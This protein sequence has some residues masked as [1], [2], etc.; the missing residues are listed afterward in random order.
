MGKASKVEE[1]VKGLD[2]L[3]TLP[4]VAMKILELVRNKES[5]LKQIADAISN[6]PSLSAEILKATNSPFYGLPKKV[7][8]IQHAVNLLGINTIKSLALGFSLVKNFRNKKPGE[9][10]YG[11]Y[12]KDSLIGAMSA[13]LLAEK[14]A[15]EAKE[16][17][18][19]LGL[20][21]NIGTLTLVNCM[22]RQYNLVMTKILKDGY[23]DHEAE[24]QII[25][26]DHMEVGEYL[27]KSW[28]LPDSFSAPIGW[29][30]Q[31][32]KLDTND[33][34]LKKYTRILHLSSLIIEM[35]N[36]S[37][38][39]LSLGFLKHWTQ[40]YDFFDKLDIDDLGSAINQNVQP[41]FALFDLEIKEKID[42]DELIKAANSEL[43]NLSQNLIKDLLQKRSEIELLRQQVD[44]D[45]MTQ[46]Y[47][48]QRFKDLLDQEIT[49]SKRYHSPLS[50]L[51][52]DIDHFKSV[53]DTF[54]HPA[55]DAV[56]KAV[57]DGLRQGLRQS[58]QVARY[59]GEEFAVILT[60]TPMD[61]ALIVA[62]RLRESIESLK[63]NH[64]GRDI[65]VTMSFGLA[66][67]EAGGS[68]SR[69][70]IIRRADAALYKAKNQG[71]NRCCVFE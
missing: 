66:S 6:D 52:T 29:H 25:G 62:D 31:P 69:E 21:Q 23:H 71:R 11:K 67:F 3:P 13:K 38:I 34:N 37:E 22:P 5:S 49:R 14:T 50:V 58:D 39:G 8:S 35:F 27:S 51:I 12:W 47:N 32:D 63:I 9:F 18:F 15:P 65:R 54:G 20:L 68:I 60:E 26:V 4:G 19:I 16:D 36:S 56:I 55:G 2:K 42:Y 45:S 28:G 7:T 10:D 43:A 48:H 70:E 44:R 46:L 17:F 40:R 33:E 30:H 53:N 64:D 61:G 59:G 41:L 57:A 24:K 1:L